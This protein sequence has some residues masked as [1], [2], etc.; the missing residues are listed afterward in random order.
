MVSMIHK[1]PECGVWRAIGVTTWFIRYLNV[2]AYPYK[3]VS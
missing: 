2:S 1:F 3:A